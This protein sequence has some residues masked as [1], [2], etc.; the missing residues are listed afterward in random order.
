MSQE[1]PRKATHLKARAWGVVFS[2]KVIIAKR[3][4]CTGEAKTPPVRATATSRQ[5]HSIANVSDPTQHTATVCLN[6]LQT[7]LLPSW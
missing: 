1:Q 2:L 5:Q 7:H 6:T 3:M 4:A